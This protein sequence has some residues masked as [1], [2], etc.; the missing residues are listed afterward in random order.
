MAESRHTDPSLLVVATF[1]RHMAAIE[2]AQERLEQSFGPLGLV[3]LPYDF[4]QTGY[5]VPTMGIGLRKYFLAFENL[6][7]PDCLAVAK[8]QTNT[9][10]RE[11]AQAGLW[12]EVRPLNLDPGLL[13]LGKF[14]LATTKDQA[15][16]IYLRDGIHAEVT[17][18]FHAGRFEPWPWTYADYRLPNVLAFLGEA[19][20]WYRK[21]LRSQVT[22]VPKVE[23][24]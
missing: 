18:R 16:R 8:N 3:S 2:W 20:E 9:L 14:V 15:H 21:R 17:L 11:L 5:Y 1:S 12:P 23:F 13:S 22:I 19:R 7:H 24:R 10:E 6:V 4:I